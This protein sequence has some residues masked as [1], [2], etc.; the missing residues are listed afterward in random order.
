MK[1]FIC[2][3]IGH[4][5]QAGLWHPTSAGTVKWFRDWSCAR[6]GQ[7]LHTQYNHSKPKPLDIA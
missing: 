2:F 6:C 4:K 5:M 3:L 7:H 1:E